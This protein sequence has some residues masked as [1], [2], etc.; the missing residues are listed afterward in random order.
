MKL[1][2]PTPSYDAGDQARMRGALQRADAENVKRSAAV[3]FVLMTKPDGTVG[4][5]TINSS[6]API[7]TAL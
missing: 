7:W 2:T 6:G 4:R 5:L 1:S 3:D